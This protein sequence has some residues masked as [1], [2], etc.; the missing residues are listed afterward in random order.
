MLDAWSQYPGYFI[1]LALVFLGVLIAVLIA[2]SKNRGFRHIERM[3][4][5]ELDRVEESFFA[6]RLLNYVPWQ[7]WTSFAILLILI[8]SSFLADGENQ[9][10]FL[11]LTKY[12]TGAVIGSLFGTSGRNER[13]NP[14]GTKET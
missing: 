2:F 14:Q 3:K 1:A 9:K 5:M 6:G 4:A 10:V 7:F 13:D 12:V 11:E 8:L